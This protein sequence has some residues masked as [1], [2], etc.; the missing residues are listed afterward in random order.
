L[1]WGDFCFVNNTVTVQRQVNRLKDYSPNAPN[2]TRLG[3][4]D[5][6]KTMS[7]NRTLSIPAELARR[8]QVHK[9]RQEERIQLLGNQYQNNDMVFARDKGEFIDPATFRENYR[10]LLKAAGL[11][12]FTIHALRHT[13]ATRALEAGID[14][15]TVSRILGHA[16]TQITWDTYSHVLPEHQSEAMSKIA[17]HIGA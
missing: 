4:Q 6:T 9:A 17:E 2:K 14:V 7:S 3:I 13:F 5:D 16:S 15:K 10:K 11:K 12:R 8:L 1:Q